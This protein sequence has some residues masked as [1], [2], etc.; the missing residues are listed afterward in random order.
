MVD[1]R[2]VYGQYALSTISAEEA[3]VKLHEKIIER[4]EKILELNRKIKEFPAKR[5]AEEPESF[6]ELINERGRQIDLV[7][8]SIDAIKS[9]ISDETPKELKD[10]IMET[11]D[12][13]KFKFLKAVLEGKAED[14]KDV[15]EAVGTL[16]DGW[17]VAVHF[18][19]R[20]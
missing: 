5:V 7:I 12:V 18:D 14:F 2:S 4:I 3:M 15:K 16:L 10:R 20:K 19:R 9:L 11:Y 8:D 6:N 13:I 1:P 17:K